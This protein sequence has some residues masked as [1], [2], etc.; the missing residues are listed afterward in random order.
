M[1]DCSRAD[2][3]RPDSEFS[4]TASVTQTRSRE[5][6]QHRLV[7]E[8]AITAPIILSGIFHFFIFTARIFTRIT[9]LSP[10]RCLFSALDKSTRLPYNTSDSAYNDD[11]RLDLEQPADLHSAM[12]LT[13]YVQCFRCAGATILFFR[14]RRERSIY[15]AVLSGGDSREAAGAV[16]QKPNGDAAAR[17]PRRASVPSDQSFAASTGT[18]SRAQ[19]LPRPETEVRLSFRVYLVTHLQARTS[20]R[21]KICQNNTRAALI[22][23]YR[24]DK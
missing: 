21:E 13:D 18:A 5:E 17:L 1:N 22:W 23:N 14:V 11:T 24:R 9:F 12:G 16:Y 10:Y 4:A 8:A 7:E 19:Q 15:W 2:S 6:Y 3:D 20:L